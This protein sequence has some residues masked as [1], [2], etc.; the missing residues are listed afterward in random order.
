MIVYTFKYHI[1]GNDEE[2]ARHQT[3]I[4]IVFC[5]WTFFN[6]YVAPLF[7]RQVGRDGGRLQNYLL[8]KFQYLV[9]RWLMADCMK[10]D[11]LHCH[12][13][14]QPPNTPQ[15]FTAFKQ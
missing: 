1:D 8:A 4:S 2:D 9:S 3:L 7:R 12:S 11:S 6:I 15:Q 10:R 13:A 5:N 14:C